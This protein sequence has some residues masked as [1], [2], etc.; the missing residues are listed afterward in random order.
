MT[1]DNTRDFDVVVIG[2]G[3]NGLVAAGYLAREG[4]SLN[5]PTALVFDWVSE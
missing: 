5:P 2:G 1:V 3:H 4:L